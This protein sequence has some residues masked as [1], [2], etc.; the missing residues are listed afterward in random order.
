[1]EGDVC[2]AMNHNYLNSASA[3]YSLSDPNVET[4]KTVFVK[5]LM[6]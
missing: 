1:M 6:I 4:S 3:W 2:T 5:L